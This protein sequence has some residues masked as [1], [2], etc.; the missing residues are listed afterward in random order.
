MW[1]GQTEWTDVVRNT[2]ERSSDC[3]GKQWWW[4]GESNSRDR[5][6]SIIAVIF[7]SFVAHKPRLKAL[8]ISLCVLQNKLNQQTAASSN[9]IPLTVGVPSTVARMWN[10][11]SSTDITLLFNILHLKKTRGG[12]RW[13]SLNGKISLGRWESC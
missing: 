2:T 9:Q 10:I 8:Q 7:N 11:S 13:S 1:Y 12:V 3:S 5:W 4:W 6:R